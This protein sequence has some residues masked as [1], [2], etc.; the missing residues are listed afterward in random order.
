MDKEEILNLSDLTGYER[1]YRTLIQGGDITPR[2]LKQLMYQW[3]C[4]NI[5]A[6]NT[7]YGEAIKHID[8]PDFGWRMDGSK[9]QPYKT[10]IQLSKALHLLV[11]NVADKEPYIE[12]NQALYDIGRQYADEFRMR[13]GYTTRDPITS[14]SLSEDTLNP[15][16][17]PS[18]EFNTAAMACLEDSKPRLVYICAPLRGD[19][20]THIEFARQKAKEVFEA[21]DIPVCPHLMIPPIADPGN[22]EQD[23]RA[24]QMCLKLIERCNRV[25]VYGAEWSE[26]MWREIHHAERLKI[27]IYTDQKE[28][29]KSN[30]RQNPGPCR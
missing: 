15:I 2:R 18:T 11:W 13:H 25:Q 26:G 28:L 16:L 5:E 22:P 1:L 19:V 4:A 8:E 24:M 7:R 21:G 17:E 10:T 20:A 9:A 29:G 30:P 14:Y 27:P 23:H 6:Y 12:S 3:Y